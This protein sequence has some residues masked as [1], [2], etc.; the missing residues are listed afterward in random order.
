MPLT[1]RELSSPWARH[2]AAAV[3]LGL[4]LGFAGPFGSYP[5]YDRPVRYAFW[6]GL[7][8]FGYLCALVSGAV[9]RSSPFSTACHRIFAAT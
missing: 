9:I 5:A 4:L 6:L 1:K 7:T 8:A 3:A 2:V